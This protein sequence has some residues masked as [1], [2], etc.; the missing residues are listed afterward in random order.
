MDEQFKSLIDN[1]KSILILLP[2]KPFFDQVA[3]GLSLFLA[4]R[5]EKDVQIVS[6]APITVDF[7]RIIGINKVTQELGNKNLIVKFLDYNPNDIERIKY[8]L[9]EGQVYL[10]VIPKPG[11]KAPAK[12]QVQISYAGIAADVVF[13]IG[14]MNESH[15]PH[16]ANKDLSSSKLAHIGVKDVQLTDGKY[17]ISLARPSSSVSELVYYL[18]KNNGYDIDQDVASDILMGIESATANLSD[19]GATAET[20]LAVA[21]LMKRGARRFAAQSTIGP[22]N[23][24]PGAIP[25]QIPQMPQGQQGPLPQLTPQQLEQ[26]RAMQQAGFPRPG[27]SQQTGQQYSSQQMPGGFTQNPQSARQLPQQGVQIP[28]GMQ[29]QQRP[30]SQGLSVPEEKEAQGQNENIEIV[31]EANA[32]SDWLTKPKVY[33]GTSIT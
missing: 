12:D 8:D 18:L 6:N 30:K 20:F 16:L 13:L 9:D 15:F 27:Q 1:S 29:R 33:K 25:G 2:T 32:P 3:A 7:N 14:G 5:G 23:F 17:P 10:T 26:L 24:P 21:D 31:D 4:L 22:T 11:V 19:Q 28:Q